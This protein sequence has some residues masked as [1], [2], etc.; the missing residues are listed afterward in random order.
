MIESV[1]QLLYELS[2]QERVRLD[3]WDV[4]HGPT[5]GKMYEGL[6]KHVLSHAIPPDLGL[7]FVS[8]FICND[9]GESTGQIDC[10]LVKGEGER[11]PY[12]EDFKWDVRNVI[13]VVE[14]KKNLYS[15]G[16][17][18]SFAALRKVREVHRRYLQGGGQFSKK[19]DEWANRAYQAALRAFAETTHRVA[20][21]RENVSELGVELESI[22]H[23]LV[24]E[25][26]API[27]IV[28]GYH[29]FKS[30]RHYRESL[31][32]YLEESIGKVGFGPG[33]FPQ[34]VISGE[35]SLVKANGQPYSIPVVDQG[36]PF[37]L[38]TSANPLLLI[39]EFLWTRLV[40]Q[41]LIAS[42]FGADLNMESLKPFLVTKA[43]EKEGKVGWV[44][45]FH[46]LSD[47]KLSQLDAH[48]D[49]QPCFLDM[50]QFTVINLMCHGTRHFTDDP[51]FSQYL[52]EHGYTMAEFV[53]SLMATGLVALDGLEIELVTEQCDCFVLPTGEFVAAENNSGRLTRWIAN[54]VASQDDE[55]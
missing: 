36:W 50:P 39:L 3:A 26:V 32:K 30:E 23:T 15:E 27:C 55:L 16:L 48:V 43:V 22:Y 35:Y 9:A 41:H 42:T 37:Y 45:Y 4:K 52:S 28:L 5:I 46:N 38:S 6:S 40:R 47:K 1:A 12:T 53:K 17:R 8:G 34:L 10:M 25:H 24:V 13:A 29:G 14:I 19:E 18:E 11:I 21:P 31:A 20:P 44:Y 2:E 7:H 54:F 51:E 49:W 33:S